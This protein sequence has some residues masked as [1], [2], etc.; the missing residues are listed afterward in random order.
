M[1]PKANYLDCSQPIYSLTS[2]TSRSHQTMNQWNKEQS[3]LSFCLCESFNVNF[4][5][6][7][8]VAI[9]ICIRAGWYN[10]ASQLTCLL[11]PLVKFSPPDPNASSELPV[12]FLFTEA[13]S[14]I[15]LTSLKFSTVS[16]KFALSYQQC[17]FFSFATSVRQW[18]L[19]FSEPFFNNIFRFSKTENRG[20]ISERAFA[21]VSVFCATWLWSR[22]TK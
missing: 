17:I 2:F 21:I 20:K 6:L 16:S 8:F 1:V 22:R 10:L 5:L 11:T 12:Y 15:M 4:Y 9:Y 14:D 3:P 19:S 13:A 18:S 7:W